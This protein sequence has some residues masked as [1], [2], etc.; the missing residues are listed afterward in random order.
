MKAQQNFEM[1]SGDTVDIT[2]TVTDAAGAPLD[3]TGVTLYWGMGDIVKV[4]PDGI[5]TDDEVVIHLLPE[6]TVRLS[7]GHKH[8]LRGVDS[9]GRVETFLT[10]VVRINESVFQPDGAVVEPV[11]RVRLVA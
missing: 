8:Q 5:T 9:T 4:S 1:W 3:L 2:V 7:G 10:G 11:V 6:D